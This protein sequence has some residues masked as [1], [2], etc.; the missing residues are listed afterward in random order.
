VVSVCADTD[1]QAHCVV[2]I[3]ARLP[4]GID[5]VNHNVLVGDSFGVAMEIADCGIIFGM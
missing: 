1:A 3:G 2:G 5:W 4:L